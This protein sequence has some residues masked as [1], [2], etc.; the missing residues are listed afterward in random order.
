MGFFCLFS[1]SVSVFL[2]LYFLISKNTKNSM[3][4]GKSVIL[5]GEEAEPLLVPTV[6]DGSGSDSVSDFWLAG[7]LLTQGS[8]NVRAFKSTMAQIWK[9]KRGVEVRDVGRN[10]FVFRFFDGK[11]REWVLRQGPWHFDKFLV[12]LQVLDPQLAPSEVPL[13][14]VPIWVRVQD[15]PLALKSEAFARSIGDFLGGFIEWDKS[16]DHRLGSFLRVRAS[17]DTRIPIKRGKMIARSGLDSIKVWFQYERLLNF[18]YG[19][20]GLD[21]VLKDCDNWEGDLEEEGAQIFPFGTWLRA[22]HLRPNVISGVRGTFSTGGVP[23]A[24]EEGPK[25]EGV[26]SKVAQKVDPNVLV[27]VLVSSLSKVNVDQRKSLVP[28]GERVQGKQGGEVVGVGVGDSRK[29]R[30]GDVLASIENIQSSVVSEIIRKS[31]SGL[32]GGGSSCLMK[33]RGKENIENKDDPADGVVL[34]PI[35]GK[36]IV[37]VSGISA[38]VVSKV[39]DVGVLKKGGELLTEEGEPDVGGSSPN[40][41]SVLLSGS[42]GGGQ[43]RRVESQSGKK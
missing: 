12:V 15:L 20:G 1:V 42:K 19:C 28:A 34:T 30:V 43:R 5:E 17:V 25:S 31:P 2:A 35:A 23:E 14:K 41:L 24:A 4:R 27:D 9:V 18:C 40:L 6:D 3:D 36:S 8:F 32:E 38:E 11:D 21:H 22:P 29:G 7:K 13:N 16:D 37:T 26:A 33:L 39:E 10:L